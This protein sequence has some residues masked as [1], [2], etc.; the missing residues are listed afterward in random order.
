VPSSNPCIKIQVDVRGQALQAGFVTARARISAKMLFET[1]LPEEQL[2][3]AGNRKGI[4]WK[5]RVQ[6]KIVIADT[7]SPAGTTNFCVFGRIAKNVVKNW[8][9]GITAV[10][11]AN[12]VGQPMKEG[13]S[14]GVIVGVPERVG[15]FDDDQILAFWS[16]SP[17]GT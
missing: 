8:P 16:R 4:S 6:N 11:E 14:G 12:I 9:P 2:Q 17:C 13:L 1:P 5:V 3:I 15:S 10:S 7:A